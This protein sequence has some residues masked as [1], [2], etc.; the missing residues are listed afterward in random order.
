MLALL[1]VLLLAVPPVP[2]QAKT[3][4]GD[5]LRADA[6]TEELKGNY[7]QAL[8]LAE[9]AFAED[10]ADPSYILELRRVRFEAAAA[11]VKTG[12]KLRSAGKLEEALAESINTVAVRLLLVRNSL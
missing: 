4:K 3:R 10:A 9:K 7:D 1:L 5:K 6:R 8:A 12:Q 11:H 2:A